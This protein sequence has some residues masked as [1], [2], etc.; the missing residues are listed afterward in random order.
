MYQYVKS[1]ADIINSTLITFKTEATNLYECL[2]FLVCSYVSELSV[3]P[4]FAEVVY[5]GVFLFSGK[6][7]T[8]LSVTN[9]RQIVMDNINKINRI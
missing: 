6:N 4:I 8:L 5:I 7:Q 9:Y 3:S 1:K 2:I